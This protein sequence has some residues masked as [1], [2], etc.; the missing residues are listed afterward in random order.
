M[1]NGPL[2]RVN[3]NCKASMRIQGRTAVSTTFLEDDRF[4]LASIANAGDPFRLNGKI[5]TTAF[6]PD[7]AKES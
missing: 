4:F 1:P 3:V 2:K 5:G 7:D 6:H